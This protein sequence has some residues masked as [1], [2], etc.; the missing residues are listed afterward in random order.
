MLGGVILSCTAVSLKIVKSV[1]L[2][3]KEVIHMAKKSAKAPAAPKATRTS[4][5]ELS[6]LHIGRYLYR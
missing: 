2:R 1:I 6:A 3:R 5:S 4:K